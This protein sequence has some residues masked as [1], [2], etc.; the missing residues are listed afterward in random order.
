MPVCISTT[1]RCLKR[2]RQKG[3]RQLEKHGFQLSHETIGELI[4]ALTICRPILLFRSLKL[5]QYASRQ[6][7]EHYKAAKAVFIVCQT[8]PETD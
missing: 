4:F 1:L 5:S 7:A 6:A 3:T 2:Q 8:Q